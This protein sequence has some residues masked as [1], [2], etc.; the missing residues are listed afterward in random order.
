M[1]S[2]GCHVQAKRQGEAKCDELGRKGRKMCKG[3]HDKAAVSCEKRKKKE[4]GKMGALR[5]SC[6]MTAD[7]HR[8]RRAVGNRALLLLL[9]LLLLRWPWPLGAAW[10]PSSMERILLNLLAGD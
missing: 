7:E 8:G 2:M 6:F 5:L 1:F 3:G 4:K 9:L 10:G